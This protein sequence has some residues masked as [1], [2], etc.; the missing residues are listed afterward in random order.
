L[1]DVAKQEAA[2]QA[3]LD[4]E[5]FEAMRKEQ[6][7]NRQATED[8]GEQTRQL[9]SSGTAALAELLRAAGNMSGAESAFGNAQAGQGNGEQGKALASLKYA[10]ELLAEEA[11]R[12][13]QQ[14]RAEVK[15]RVTEGL[16]LMLETQIAVRERT[17]ALG[18][19]VQKG[20]RAALS[21][22]A[23][24]AK[25]EESITATAQELVNLVEETEFGIALPAALAAVRDATEVVALSL[26]DGDASSEVV[27]SEK[28]IEADLKA[29]L[30]IVGEMSEANSRNGRRNRGG[31]PEEE[32]KELNRII[33]ELRMLSLLE[34]RVQENTAQADAKRAGG[35]PLSPELRKRIEQ[36][37]GRQADIQEAAEL[38]ANER[39][40][41]LPQPE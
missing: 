37:E 16:T 10:Q 21:A 28:Q 4:K 25:R 39:S 8:V 11:E 29:M 2:A 17:E 22:V 20:A 15:K 40:N 1:A 27:K 5:R 33:S 14:L 6:Q 41:E 7:A 36:L 12:L 30:E 35:Q 19:E 18:P 9:G 38:L 23:A 24:L 3:A 26:A 13:A 34:T 32:R 31:S